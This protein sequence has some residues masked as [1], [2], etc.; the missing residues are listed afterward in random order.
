MP[1]KMHKNAQILTFNFKNWGLQTY[2]PTFYFITP[3]FACNCSLVIIVFIDD[4][5][6][7]MVVI[8]HTCVDY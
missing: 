8:L 3:G 7:N 1:T 6:H 2:V 5:S 4:I